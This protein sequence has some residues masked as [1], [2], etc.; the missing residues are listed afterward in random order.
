MSA[1]FWLAYSLEGA[2][3]AQLLYGFDCPNDFQSEVS[4]ISYLMKLNV[5]HDGF[6]FFLLLNIVSVSSSVTTASNIRAPNLMPSIRGIPTR[7]T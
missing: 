7:E 6:H 4:I 3:L 1:G 2:P 5:V